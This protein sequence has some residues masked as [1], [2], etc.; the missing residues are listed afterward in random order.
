MAK[1]KKSSNKRK[2]IKV[3][4]TRNANTW[5]E[6]QY[7]SKIRSALRNAFRFWKPFSICLENASRP[8]KGTNKLQ[9]KEYQCN[10]CKNWFPRKNVNI[11]HIEECGS[12]KTYDDIVPFIKK[13]CVEDVSKLQVL[14]KNCHKQK[15]SD[16]LKTKKKQ[17]DK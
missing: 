1:R 10:H 5:T 8:Y 13:L 3:E 11:D 2:N 9:K 16:Y 15:T 12:L 4:R 17:N 6:A 7:F 14:C